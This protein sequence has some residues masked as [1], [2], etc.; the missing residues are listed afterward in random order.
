MTSEQVE[1]GETGD[2]NLL[3]PIRDE[4]ETC[5]T[6]EEL[7]DDDQLDADRVLSR[8]IRDGFPAGITLAEAFPD[9]AAFTEFRDALD[10]LARDY[11]EAAGVFQQE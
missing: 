9:F 1:R 5:D 10:R 8:H 3:E 4:R 6:I 11:A 7:C 2:A